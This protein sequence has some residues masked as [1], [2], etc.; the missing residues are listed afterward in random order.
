MITLRHNGETCYISGSLQLE[1]IAGLWPRRQQLL[2]AET[3]YLD[4]SELNYSD[5]AGLAFLLQLWQQTTATD[6]QVRLIAPSEQLCRLIA[7]YNLQAFFSS[8]H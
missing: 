1:D 4:L 3:R 2:T 7:L 8:H 6:T 5:S